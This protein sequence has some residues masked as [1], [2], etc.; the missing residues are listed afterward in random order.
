M[1]PI[2]ELSYSA[3]PENRKKKA[4]HKHRGEKF[5]ELVCL[6]VIDNPYAKI[7]TGVQKAC[8]QEKQAMEATLKEEIGA[9]IRA[10][11]ADLDLIEQS[12]T[13]AQDPKSIEARAIQLQTVRDGRAILSDLVPKLMRLG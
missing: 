5:K 2:Y 9:V 8:E 6:P 13:P 12:R 10:I 4:V 1:R 7:F 11:L 3:Y